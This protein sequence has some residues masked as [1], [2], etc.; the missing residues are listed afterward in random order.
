[1]KK[2]LEENR[3]LAALFG[4]VNTS[5]MQEQELEIDDRLK[6][7]KYHVNL[8]RRY[9]S[10]AYSSKILNDAEWYKQLHFLYFNNFNHGTSFVGNNNFKKYYPLNNN[11]YNEVCGSLEQKGFICREKMSEKP[12]GS[13][14]DKRTETTTYLA[15]IYDTH[16]DTII[17]QKITNNSFYTNVNKVHYSEIPKEVLDIIL[18]DRKLNIVHKRL[19][20]K[21]YRFNKYK[22]F[23]GVDP[24]FIHR[25]EGR[26]YMSY[27]LMDDLRLS[28]KEVEEMLEHIEKFGYI[29]WNRVNVYEENLDQD[30]RLRVTHQRLENSREVDIITP[31][32]QLKREVIND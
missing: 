25:E 12:G 18:K 7:S 16:T 1:M 10:K 21:V 23:G 24:N 28:R 27:R 31:T 11:Q 5:S 20:F 2:N 6:L 13:P 30:T 29:Y 4:D 14:K 9:V 32:H 17:K 8:E 3:I 15:P 22:L 19:I 26:L